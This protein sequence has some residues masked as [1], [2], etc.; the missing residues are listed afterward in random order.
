MA[1]YTTADIKALREKTGAGMLD[2]KKALD[3]ANGDA[4]K[5]IEIIRVKGLKGIAKREGR[6]A[7]EGLIAFDIRDSA[8]GRRMVDNKALLESL[9]AGAV[10]ALVTVDFARA[11]KLALSPTC[12]A[13]TPRQLGPTT[14][15]PVDEVVHL[16]RYGNRAWFGP[17]RR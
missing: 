9:R 10:T 17:R 2:V 1:N 14:R 6:T 12:G 15:R 13:I 4:E 16:D 3:E 11:A 7:S 5:A 8:E